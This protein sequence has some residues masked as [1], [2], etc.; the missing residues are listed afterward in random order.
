MIATIRDEDATYLLNSKSKIAYV[1]RVPPKGRNNKSNSSNSARQTLHC[2]LV[3]KTVT[4]CPNVGTNL[5]FTV[6]SARHKD[7]LSKNA[8]IKAKR[9]PT[10][11]DTPS[12]E[13]T[14]MPSRSIRERKRRMKKM[15][16]EA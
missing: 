3:T 16:N 15:G 2:S 9:R 6:P 12:R 5:H 1:A 10:Q 8:L 13:K 4:Q 11:G 7:I 14:K